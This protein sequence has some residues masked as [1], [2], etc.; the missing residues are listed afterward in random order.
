MIFE[1]L[2]TYFRLGVNYK[3][4][5]VLM[6]KLIEYSRYNYKKEQYRARMKLNATIDWLKTLGKMQ[7]R[8]IGWEKKLEAYGIISL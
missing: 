6:Y 1:R 5:H 7:F 8:E 2:T 4:F 3:T